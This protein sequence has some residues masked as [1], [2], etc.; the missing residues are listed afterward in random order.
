M[1]RALHLPELAPPVDA[2][3]RE[4]NRSIVRGR[5]VGQLR[6]RLRP[7]APRLGT[8][9]RRTL[10]RV[11][12]ALRRTFLPDVALLSPVVCGDVPRPTPPALAGRAVERRRLGGVP[13]QRMSHVHPD[14][15]QRRIRSPDSVRRVPLA[16]RRIARLRAGA[17][18]SAPQVRGPEIFS[19]TLTGASAEIHW[20]Q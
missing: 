14:G 2:R 7:D 15:R 17:Q 4:S 5:G 19:T 11:A 6:R 13:T 18:R 1:D 20:S 3:D 16:L 12:T 10:G 8:K 9:L